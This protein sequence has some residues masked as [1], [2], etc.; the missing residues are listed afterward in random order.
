MIYAPFGKRFGAKVI[1]LLILGVVQTCLLLSCKD[2]WKDSDH[3]LSLMYVMQWFFQIGYSSAFLG[4]FGATP[5]KMV[6]RMKVVRANGED[7]S[8]MRALGRSL[9]EV[10]SAWLLYGGYAMAAFDEERRTLHDRAADTR[11]IKK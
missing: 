3:I 7:I 9:A 10:L 2:L 5:G 11:V 1:D 4:K 8:A 6:L